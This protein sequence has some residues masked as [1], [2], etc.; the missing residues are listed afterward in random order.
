MTTERVPLGVLDL[1]PVSSGS[2]PS[3]ALGNSIELARTAE[4][5][6][7]V[8]Y[9]FAEHHL[10]PGV[11]GT[12]PPVL[13]AAAAA[14]TKRIR[15]GSGG[16]Q[17][18][19]RTALSV[20]EEFGILDALHPGR[21]DLGIG[22]SVGRQA[23]SQRH[24]PK[25]GDPDQVRP[26]RRPA[27]RTTEGLLIPERPSLKGL[28]NSPRLALT[29]DLTRQPG[30]EAPPY[31]QMMEDVLGLLEGTYRSSDGIDPHPVPGSGA[32]VDLWILGSSA[33]E[34]AA[35]AG[36]LGLR[37]AANYH[38]SPSTVLE[39]VEAYR[40]AFV[41]SAYLDRPYVVTSADVVVGPDDATANELAE[42][43][44]LWVHSIRSGEGA[45]P[46]PSP[47]EARRH[48]WTE[49][50]RALVRDRT[51]TQFVGSAASVAAQLEWLREATDA[52]EL[53]V[54]TI[55]HRHE[56]RIRSYRLLAEEWTRAARAAPTPAPVRRPVVATRTDVVPAL[57]PTR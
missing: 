50:E 1:V 21:I 19:H 5:L 12:S 43:F 44:G 29:A 2:D 24:R 56:D 46:F 54:T 22:R 34:S 33:G 27:Y 16:V 11:A 47:V 23:L 32:G 25:T 42:G 10:N 8:R 6:G 38:V 39:A 36:R 52:D 41:P 53:M 30:A 45:I 17:S 28:A 31:T 3:T 4:S 51:D 18:G 55:T 57:G 49:E 14:A 48:H 7:Y 35:L 9:W 20:V 37:F 40:E 26:R 15:V 13:V